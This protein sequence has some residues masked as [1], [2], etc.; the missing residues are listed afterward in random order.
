M[1]N[2]SQALVKTLESWLEALQLRVENIAG[3]TR[4]KVPYLDVP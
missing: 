3:W 1:P 2:V 4:S